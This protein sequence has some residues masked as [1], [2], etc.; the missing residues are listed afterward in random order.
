MKVTFQ[1]TI[2]MRLFFIYT[3]GKI[4]LSFKNLFVS[5]LVFGVFDFFVTP[6]WYFIGAQSMRLEK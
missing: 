4:Q 5:F 2:K 6:L 1:I 3:K